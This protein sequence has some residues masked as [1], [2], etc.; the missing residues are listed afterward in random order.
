MDKIRGLLNKYRSFILYAA[1]GV[2]TTIVNM[3]VYYLCFN[4]MGIPNVPSTII[5][6][7]MAVSFAFIT[8]KLWVFD[9]KSFSAKTLKHEIPTFFGARIATGLL[10]VGIMYLAVDVLNWNS[11]LWKLISNIL[12]I[13]LNYIASKLII[14]KHPAKQDNSDGMIS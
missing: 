14:F 7:V 3:V 4:I 1:F 10:D 5:A 12:V 9:S 13:I 8:N 11:T 2:L 6:W